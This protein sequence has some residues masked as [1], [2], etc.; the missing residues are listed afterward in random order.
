L[1]NEIRIGR[2][3]K[4]QLLSIGTYPSVTLSEAKEEL[5]KARKQLAKNADQSKAKQDEKPKNHIG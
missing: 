4:L 5:S 2:K 1:E 3:E